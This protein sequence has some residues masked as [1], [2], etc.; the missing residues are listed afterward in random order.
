MSYTVH[1]KRG[2]H[3]LIDNQTKYTYGME[4][5]IL[6][7]RFTQGNQALRGYDDGAGQGVFGIPRAP[8]LGCIMGASR[9]RRMRPLLLHPSSSLGWSRRSGFDGASC[10]LQGSRGGDNRGHEARRGLIREG[11]ISHSGHAVLAR[12]IL[13]TMTSEP[14]FLEGNGKSRVSPYSSQ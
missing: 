13:C 2:Q 1:G 6:H 8:F 9:G 14:A 5:H 11:H 12:F 4:T 10:A 7:I 3:S